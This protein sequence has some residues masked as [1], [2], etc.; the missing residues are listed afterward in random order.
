MVPPAVRSGHLLSQVTLH[1]QLSLAWWP[2]L[3]KVQNTLGSDSVA[4]LMV[5]KIVSSLW[6]ILGSDV[7][8]LSQHCLCLVTRAASLSVGLLA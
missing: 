5:V 2:E 4:F 3:W 8:K 7:K 1:W 6:D